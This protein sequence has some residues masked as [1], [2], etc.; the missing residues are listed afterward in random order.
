M[1][2]TVYRIGGATNKLVCPTLFIYKFYGKQR[3]RRSHHRLWRIGRHGGLHPDQTGI[4][5]LLLEAGPQVDFTRQ[6]GAKAVYELPYRG[7]GKPG[8]LPHVFQASEFNANQW[9]DEQQ[10]PYTHDPKSPY[11]WVRVRMMGGKSNF[12][13][14]MSYRLSDFEFKGKDHD[15][16]G[17]NWPIS[18][19]ELAPFYDR[20]D[21]IFR[22]AGRKEGLAQ[23]PDGLFE[24]DTSPDSGAALRFAAA[25]K[26]RGMTLTKIRRSQGNG[27]LAS[28]WNLLLPDAHGDGQIDHCVKCDCARNHDG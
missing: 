17:E 12:W 13:A 28:S 3:I 24:D 25:G 4:N 7:F 19:A 1:A 15:G 21:P 2:E 23:L 6:R 14:R 9:V 8:K 18:Y 16:F 22:V 26:S 11:N 10:V 20:V 27:Q 5:C